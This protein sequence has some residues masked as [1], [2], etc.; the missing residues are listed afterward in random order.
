MRLCDVIL[1]GY[2]NR[3]KRSCLGR[4]SIGTVVLERED[5][6][7]SVLTVDFQ[8]LVNPRPFSRFQNSSFGAWFP[9]DAAEGFDTAAI[10]SS[11][12]G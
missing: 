10:G 6:V 1:D 2:K 8:E 11:P 12:G 7:M 4:V 3:H 5:H 9:A